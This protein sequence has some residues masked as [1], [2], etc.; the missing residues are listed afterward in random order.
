MQSIR[1]DG[2]M[3]LLGC[4]IIFASIAV[5]GAHCDAST[6]S[7]S[8]IELCSQA[9]FSKI[10]KVL[11]EQYKALSAEL[12]P[13]LRADLVSTQKNWIRL[14][15]EQCADVDEESSGQEGPIERLSCR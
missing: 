1:I 15:D 5:A 3:A 2:R 12:S 6:T 7:N 14:R 11:N 13:D 10:D 9:S 4:L 8:D